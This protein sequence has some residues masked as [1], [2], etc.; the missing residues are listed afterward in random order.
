MANQMLDAGVHIVNALDT[1]ASG[2]RG[3]L[4]WAFRK[5]AKATSQGDSLSEAMRQFPRTFKPLDVNIVDAGEKSG[6]LGFMIQQLSH[7][8]G[9]TNKM[10]RTIRSGLMLPVLIIHAAAILIPFI[11]MIGGMINGDATITQYIFAVLRFVA[12]FYIPVAVIL[13][14]IYLTP[15]RGPIRWIFDM[16]ISRI[17]LLGGAIKNLGLSRYCRVF[18]LTIESGIP[19][20][21]CSEIAADS[22]LNANVKRM[23]RRV[24]ECTKQG[25]PASAGF[26]REVP[27]QFIEIWRVGEETGDI[28][29]SAMKLA[30]NYAERAENRLAALATWLPRIIYFILMLYMAHTIVMFWS[31]YLS[32]AMAG[33]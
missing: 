18:A 6:N 30:D 11:N 24:P 16:L 17:P 12:N 2:R 4:G 14:I 5:L 10:G 19:I 8:Y 15:Q 25:M 9:F 28:D 20:H 31:S 29:K 3:R 33:L 23:F 7:W 1:V 26:S 22:T 32:G 21:E 13:G 27:R